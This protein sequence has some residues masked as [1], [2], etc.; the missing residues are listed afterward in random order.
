MPP[1]IAETFP[2]KFESD[3][4]KAPTLSS[5]VPSLGHGPYNEPQWAVQ[6]LYILTVDSDLRWRIGHIAALA[7]VPKIR[8]SSSLCH[9]PSE[10]TVL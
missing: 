2:E 1:R 4:A 5:A 9:C 7:T 8:T 10:P 6:L 3:L